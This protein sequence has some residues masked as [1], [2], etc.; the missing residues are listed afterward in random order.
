MLINLFEGFNRGL[1]DDDPDVHPTLQALT[2]L[3]ERTAPAVFLGP[4]Q[5]QAFDLA[6]KPGLMATRD[7]LRQSLTV[8]HR[9]LVHLLTETE[10][11]APNTWRQVPLLRHH[12]LVR[13]DA[14]REAFLSSYH[15]SLDDELGLRV[16]KVSGG[17][18]GDEE[19]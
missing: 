3:T 7:L 9:G 15:L 5:V 2:R 16:I 4:E 13:L 19:D 11:M 6:A 17:E 14:N 18:S 12:R 10:D 8:S 1:L